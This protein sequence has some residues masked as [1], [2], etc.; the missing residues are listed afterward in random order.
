MIIIIIIIKEKFKYINVSDLSV[1]VY[2]QEGGGGLQEGKDIRGIKAFINFLKIGAEP[3]NVAYPLPLASFLAF[4]L[5]KSGLLEFLLSYL[6]CFF[7]FTAVNLWNHL[8]DAE[9]DAKDGRRGANFLIERKR[10][11]AFFVISFYFFSALMLLFSRDAVS[12]PLFAICATLTWLYS[13]KMFFG[14]RFRRFK[15]DYRS[16]VLTYLIVTPSFPALLWTFFAPICTTALVFSSIFAMLYLSGVLLKDLKDI[17]A[18]SLAGYRTLGVVF[19]ERKLFK[20]SASILLS[21]ISLI[22]IFSL[23]G[24]LPFRASL[25]AFLLIPASYSVLS[26]KRRNW[27]LSMEVINALRLYTLSYPAAFVL[28]ALLSFEV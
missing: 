8:N 7:F 25:A 23:L 16:E 10:E 24:Y 6:F 1:M 27:E 28:L 17:T 26:I 21:A 14:K 22:P 5:S 9:D 15:E 12:L 13:D 2:G 11:A 4:S 18:D 19:S 3:I 20:L